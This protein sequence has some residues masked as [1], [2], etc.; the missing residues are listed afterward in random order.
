M[1]KDVNPEIDEEIFFSIDVR[2]PVV[3]VGKRRM[4]GKKDEGIKK[5][6]KNR[7]EKNESYRGG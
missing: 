6:K 2:I 3:L 4:G 7:K 5:G 1:V